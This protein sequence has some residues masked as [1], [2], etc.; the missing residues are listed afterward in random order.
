MSPDKKSGSP[1]QARQSPG[2]SPFAEAPE[3]T[4][5]APLHVVAIG[6]G[7]GLSTLLRG[8]RRHVSVPGQP[9]GSDA[10]IAD[11]AAVVTVTDDGGSSGRLRKD[12]NM[13]PPG[14]LRNCMVALSEEEDLLSK[15][16]AHRFRAGD[17]L[18][19][20][21]F[22]N[23]FVAALT[24]LTGDF[25]HAVQLAS[26]ILATR[27]RIYPV[28]TANATLV[29]RMTDGS[30][31]RGETSITASKQ[32][33]AEL[34]LD[35]PDAAATPETLDA[36]KRADLISVGPGSLYTS[37]VTNLLV[38]GIPEA[39]A[40]ARGTRVFI[41][42]LMSQANESLGLT[43]SQHIERIYEHTGAPI[44]DYA[45]V[46][47]G[48]FSDETL[49]RYAAEHAQPI[50]ADLERIEQLGVR[51]IAGDFASED[52]VVR[53]NANRVTGA[54]LTLGRAAAFRRT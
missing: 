40:A 11:L 33:I 3:V 38:K 21:N 49:A 9:A 27:G 17:A 42:N 53:H 24:E 37:L 46:N 51:C 5:L 39:L 13:L 20:H 31:V 52:S 41:C 14:D 36:I 32:V 7:T 34:M 12:F 30:L 10:L 43:A 25:A 26:K 8:L 50:E 4:A 29:A 2:L 23:L 22:G 18:E 15:L 19:G 44:F 1:N 16:F 47:T 54:L 6:G 28:T 35:P 45:I 48:R